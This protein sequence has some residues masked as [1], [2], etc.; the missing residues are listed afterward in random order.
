MDT[1]SADANKDLKK[2][3]EVLE[4][5]VETAT[6]DAESS[7]LN[8]KLLK[9]ADA[10][11]NVGDLTG[12]VETDTGVYVAKLISKMDREATDQEKKEIVEERKQKQYTDLLEKWKKDT[13]IEVNKKEWKKVDFEDQGIKVKQTAAEPEK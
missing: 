3:A 2:A 7:N 8:E 4:K 12:L 5:E 13:K 1:T 10:L 9:A 6:F 11:E